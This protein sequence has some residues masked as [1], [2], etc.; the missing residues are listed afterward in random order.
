MNKFVLFLTKIAKGIVKPLFPLKV[1]G[2]RDVERKKC[3]VVGNHISGWDPIMYTLATRHQISFVYKAEFRKV[4][5]LRWVFDGVD[6]IP[7]RRGEV[8]MSASK[9]SV[10]LLE[11]NKTICLF[12]E[13][14]RNPNVDCL[15][16][17]RTGAALY[18]LKTHAPLRPFYI[19]EKT[20]FFRKNYIYIGEEFTLEQFYDLPINKDTLV[21]ATAIIKQKVDEIRLKLNDELLKRGVKR[22]KRT[23]KEIERTQK[24]NNRQRTLA[25]TLANTTTSNATKHGDE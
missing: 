16:D 9:M 24:Y 2:P 19:W 5:F 22:R 10:N 25:K 4:L 23:K 6:C 1:F 12:P 3:I 7:V 8:D 17:F 13:G 11:E 18:A 15:Q 20:K 21:Q 14:T